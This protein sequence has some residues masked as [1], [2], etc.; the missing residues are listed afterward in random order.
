MGPIDAHIERLKERWPEATAVETPGLGTIIR[1]P[2]VQLQAGWS[3]P[4]TR[5]LFLAP[6]GYPFANP[7]CFWTDPDLRLANGQVPQNTQLNPMPGVTEP[8]LWF[9]WH[10]QRPWNPNRDD[11]LTWLAVIRQ[12]LAR[13]T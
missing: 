10:L 13:P 6:Q 7:D 5:V 4:S 12:R 1:I 3:K 8:L 2:S 11:L 9:S